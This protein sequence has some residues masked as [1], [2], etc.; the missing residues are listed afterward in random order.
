[1]NLL[2][3][4]TL[5]SILA[6]LGLL[7]LEGAPNG[8]QPPAI[9]PP[10]TAELQGDCGDL[11]CPELLGQLQQIHPELTAQFIDNCPGDPAQGYYAPTGDLALQVYQRDGSQRV[12]FY[13]WEPPFDPGSGSGER[14]GYVLGVLPYPGEE[15]DFPAKIVSD[16][17][18]IQAVLDRYPEKVAQMA[19]DCA[20]ASGDINILPE[21]N[22]VRLQCYFQAGVSLAD[23][24]GDGISDGEYSMGAGVD[25]IR[26]L[27]EGR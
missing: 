11:T 27:G 23:V 26:T 19:W 15:A 1:M 13:C 17:P 21:E 8:V 18:A 16:V 7:P 2:E 20:L 22:A 9:A 14:S 3:S 5:A 25:F 6:C 24:D 10:A 12:G 4:W